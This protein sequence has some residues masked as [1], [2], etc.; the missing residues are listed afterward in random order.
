VRALGRGLLVGVL[1]PQH[2]DPE[3]HRAEDPDAQ[4]EHR[5]PLLGPREDREAPAHEVQHRRPEAEERQ[6]AP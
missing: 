1:A 2:R 6:Q 3:Q 4:P 5:L